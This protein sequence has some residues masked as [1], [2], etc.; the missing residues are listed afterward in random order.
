VTALVKLNLLILSGREPVR[1]ALK[2]YYVPN[3]EA[4][5]H[6]VVRNFLAQNQPDRP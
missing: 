5:K 1:G 6:P 3:E 2:N 4:L